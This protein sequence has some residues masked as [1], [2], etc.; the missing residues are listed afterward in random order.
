MLKVVLLGLLRDLPSGN[1]GRRDVKI[2]ISNQRKNG[3]T[4]ERGR[5]KLTEQYQVLWGTGNLTK[6]MRS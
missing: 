2:G 5:T 4:L 3:P 1:K 6:E